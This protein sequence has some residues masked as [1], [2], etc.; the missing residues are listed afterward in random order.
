MQRIHGRRYGERAQVAPPRPRSRRPARACRPRRA[1]RPGARRTA[2]CP[3]R[4]PATP[5]GDLAGHAGEEL[6]DQHA[7]SRRPRAA[8]GRSRRRCACRRPTSGRA[9]SSSGRACTAAGSARPGSSPRRGRSGRGASARP[10]GCRRDRRRAAGA[11]ER[12]EQLADGPER[13][14]GDAAVALDAEQLREPLG[15]ELAVL[16]AAGQPA[17]LSRVSCGPSSSVSSAA[18]VS[19]S[20]IGQ[21]VMPSPYGRQRPRS[22]VAR[23]GPSGTPRTRRDFPTPGGAE[24]RE[25]AARPVG[26]G[27]LERLVEQARA[28]AR[29]R[30]SATSRRRAI[31]SALG[32]HGRAAATRAPAPPCP[33]R[34]GGSS[35]LDDD[36][37]AHQPVRALAEQDLAG[38]ARLLEPRGRVHGVA[39]RDRLLARVAGD[40]LAGVHADPAR[41]RHAVVALELLVE[42]RRAPRASRRPR[43]TA[44]SASS[45]CTAGMPNT[46]MTA[47][48]MNFSTVPPWRS[49]IARIDVEVAGHDAPERLRIEPL[50]ERRRARDVAEDDRHGLADLGGL[51]FVEPVPAVA[52][53]ALPLGVLRAAGRT[54]HAGHR[55]RPCRRSCAREADPGS[56]GS[57]VLSPE[58]D[59]EPVGELVHHLDVVRGRQQG[60]GRG[61]AAA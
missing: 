47:S 21:N 5:L 7:R 42:R 25:Q 14:L 30:R 57:V 48:P 2:G 35:R 31:P 53:E 29:V 8:R 1:S 26:D 13:L 3:R 56:A 6:R 4:P 17:S 54:D 9:S 36:G 27:A 39:G 19:I 22:T 32:M 16:A 50:A 49:R 58:P 55:R 33:W 51:R 18:R 46:A 59:P 34:R 43:A 10:T 40:D 37:V 45:S 20:T 28:R 11:R 61:I 38:A 52:A 41:D 44:R 15:D 12:L 23:R 60:P 24:D